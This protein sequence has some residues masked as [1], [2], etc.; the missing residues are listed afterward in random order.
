MMDN[1][2]DLN[3]STIVVDQEDYR[4]F[5]PPKISSNDEE[6]RVVLIN[7]LFDPPA[8]DSIVVSEGPFKPKHSSQD[9]TLFDQSVGRDSLRL[10]AEMLDVVHGRLSPEGDPATLIVLDFRFQPNAIGRRFRSAK[11]I[12]TFLD[13][14]VNSRHFA[15]AVEDI[16]P[17]ESLSLL[18]STKHVEDTEGLSGGI[19]AGPP[20]TTI[21][22]GL[23]D[24]HK[25]T[26]DY[27]NF[28]KLLG[29]KRLLGR[30]SGPKNAVTWTLLENDD[31]KSGIPTLLQ[32]AILL[33]RSNNKIDENFQA[34]VDIE[35]EVDWLLHRKVKAHDKVNFD[36]TLD[37]VGK[38]WKQDNFGVIDLKDNLE[39]VDLKALQKVVDFV[40]LSEPDTTRKG[41]D[42]P[43]KG[44]E[45]TVKGS[46]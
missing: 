33:N 9:E 2:E 20:G 21:S 29:A 46:G 27:E 45:T 39:K 28:A 6:Q 11:I 22:A 43:V 23:Q 14:D 4:N 18:R 35:V 12:V 24:Q 34:T 16:A 1:K 36:P 3:P 37:H 30:I 7:H 31:I 40:S 17:D 5:M 42:T 15:P 44:P 41:P 25:T 38:L 32:G 19:S 26:L 10:M 13:P 8:S